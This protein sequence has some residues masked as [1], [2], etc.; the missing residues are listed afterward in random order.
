MALM[1]EVLVE[2]E[3]EGAG[4]MPPCST[5]G[6]EISNWKTSVQVPE[7]NIGP[8]KLIIWIRYSWS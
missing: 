3:D 4:M 8:V 6:G 5:E 2:L 7:L 1:V